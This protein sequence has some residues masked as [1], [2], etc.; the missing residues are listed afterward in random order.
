MPLVVDGKRDRIEHVLPVAF[1]P[2]PVLGEVDAEGGKSLR[3][4]GRDLVFARPAVADQVLADLLRRVHYDRVLV[5]ESHTA[6]VLGESV[7]TGKTSLRMLGRSF[8]NERSRVI[9]THP[10]PDEAFGFERSLIRWQEA[11]RSH[12]ARD[13]PLTVENRVAEFAKPGIKS[14]DRMVVDHSV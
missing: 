13:Q 8:D 7:N 3:D 2:L 12:A 5:P 11:Q 9:E 1:F 10:V 4:A 6:H 14:E